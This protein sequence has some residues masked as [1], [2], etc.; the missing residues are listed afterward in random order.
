MTWIVSLRGQVLGE[1]DGGS[2]MVA[3]E[4]VRARWHF[5]HRVA[6]RVR[7]EVAE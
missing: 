2:W 4:A 3:R 5:P 1:V 7:V 6:R